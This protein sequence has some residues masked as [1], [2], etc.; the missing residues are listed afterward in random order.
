MYYWEVCNTKGYIADANYR[1][2]E[3][4][5]GQLVNDNAHYSV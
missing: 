5:L 1:H 4:Y 3:E 2:I